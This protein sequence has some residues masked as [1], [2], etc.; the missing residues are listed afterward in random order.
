MSFFDE[1]SYEGEFKDGKFHGMGTMTYPN[2]DK[3]TGDWQKGAPS[4]QGTL[5]LPDGRHHTG[6]YKD[7]KI[8]QIK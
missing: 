8:V 3:Y 7:G 4:G 5:T 1:R 2:G 6:Q